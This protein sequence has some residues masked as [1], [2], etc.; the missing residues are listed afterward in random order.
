MKRIY[1][2]IIASIFISVTV[3]AQLTLTKAFNEPI[4]GDAYVNKG[5]DTVNTV[6]KNVGANQIWNFSAFTQNTVTSSGTFTSASSVPTASNYA[7]CNLVEDQGSNNYLFEKTTSTPT[8]QVE[9]LGM[10]NGT[11][12]S[13]NFTNSAIA[14]IWP[15]S[16]GYNNTDNFSGTVSSSFGA[17]NISGTLN[18]SATGTG[19]INLPGSNTLNNIL[20]TKTTLTLNAVVGTAP[21][22]FTLNA[23]NTTYNYYHSSNKFALV[24]VKYEKQT[25]TSVGG[26]TVTNTA[27]AKIN[28]VAI[29]GIN[30]KNFDATF[31]IFPNPATNNIT[32][33]LT[34]VNNT[35]GSIYLINNLGSIIKTIDL[36]NESIIK[37]EISIND[38][39]KG[40]YFVKTQLGN[41]SSTRKLIVN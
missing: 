17:G 9:L 26:P 4:I 36:G 24:E 2:T 15:V 16:F 19:T 40:I 37:K 30:D 14:A 6:P 27:S 11:V 32:V 7:G 21:F 8:T 41:S 20:Q 23:Q 29:T 33:N 31:Q 25:L 10:Q 18:N 39:P 38:L 35:N 12:T 5:F 3:N 1:T 13:F 34:N 28:T 22:Q